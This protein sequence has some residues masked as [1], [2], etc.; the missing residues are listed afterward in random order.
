MRYEYISSK[1]LQ[2]S[3]FLPLGTQVLE[4]SLVST[5]DGIY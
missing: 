4:D 2:D 1:S 3:V 5:P